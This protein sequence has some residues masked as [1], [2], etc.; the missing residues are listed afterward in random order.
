MIAC[1]PVYRTYVTPNHPVSDH[2]RRYIVQAVACAKRRAPGVTS[3]VFDFIQRLLLQET[4]VDTPEGCEERA[5]FV[6]KFQQI[7]SPVAAKGIEDTALYVFNR[8]LSLN[9]VGSEP[10]Q[11]GLEPAAVHDWFVERRR[12]WPSALSATS[13]HD[14]K[15]GEDMRARINVLSEIPGAWKAAVTNGGR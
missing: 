4:V 3:L 2:D 1:F 7:T 8:L 11:F 5:R 14:T 15:R 13:T 10:T 9:E 12:D 6:G